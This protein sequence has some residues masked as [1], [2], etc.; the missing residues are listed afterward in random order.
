MAAWYDV[1]AAAFLARFVDLRKL[2]AIIQCLGIR[3]K[4]I[5]NAGKPTLIEEIDK[6]R[7]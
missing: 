5:S 3:E 1:D 4:K 7:L 2:V 6:V